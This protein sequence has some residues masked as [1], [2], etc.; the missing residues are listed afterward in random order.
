MSVKKKYVNKLKDSDLIPLEY[1]EDISVDIDD[2]LK[3]IEKEN[4]RQSELY[5]SQ[6]VSCYLSLGIS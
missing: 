5:K 3:E 2:V 6:A 1:V 4:L